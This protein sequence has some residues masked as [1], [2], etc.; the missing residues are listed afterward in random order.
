MEVTGA[1]IL[2]MVTVMEEVGVE[3]GGTA[4]AGLASS[5]EFILATVGNGKSQI[6]VLEKLESL[7]ASVQGLLVLL[8]LSSPI[9]CMF[10]YARF[11]NQNFNGR[12]LTDK[13]P[14]FFSR[15]A[16]TRLKDALRIGRVLE[17][18]QKQANRPVGRHDRKI[19]SPLVENPAMISNPR[20]L[21]VVREH[22]LRHERS[23]G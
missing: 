23:P 13:I 17:K 15:Y 5:T 8:C 3:A 10:W 7:P 21:Q 4:F 12:K 20:N 14:S 22:P 16:V 19:R 11:R 18:I 1:E 2:P 6:V 9:R